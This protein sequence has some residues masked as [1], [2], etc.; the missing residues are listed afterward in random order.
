MQHDGMVSTNQIV[1]IF[2]FSLGGG[3]FFTMEKI[4][5]G[6]FGGFFFFFFFWGYGGIKEANEES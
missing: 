4:K 5:L 2:F 6:V 1:L 3:I